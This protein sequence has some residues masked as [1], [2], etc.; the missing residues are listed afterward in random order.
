MAKT[1]GFRLDQYR[2]VGNG[3]LGAESV[4]IAHDIFKCNVLIVA[5]IWTVVWPRLT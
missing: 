1:R 3:T 4:N 5:K 2:A